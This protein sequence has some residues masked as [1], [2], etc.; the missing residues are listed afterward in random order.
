M[1]EK[2]VL[3]NKV[4]GEIEEYYIGK[5]LRKKINPLN[6]TYLTRN[7]LDNYMMQGCEK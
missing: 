2:V 4:T 5:P 3:K 7:E 6:K 1:K